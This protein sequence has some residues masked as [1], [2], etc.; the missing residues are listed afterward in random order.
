MEAVSA[1]SACGLIRASVDAITGLMA[2]CHCLHINQ[3]EFDLVMVLYH[4]SISMQFLASHQVSD[5]LQMVIKLTFH[6]I[7]LDFVKLNCG[8]KP[9]LLCR[10]IIDLSSR[11]EALHHSQSIYTSA[12]ETIRE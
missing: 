2:I 1:T 8:T 12:S 4:S 3:L 5:Q 11:H 9:T 6:Q 10:Y 7:E